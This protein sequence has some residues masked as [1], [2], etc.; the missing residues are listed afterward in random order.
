LSNHQGGILHQWRRRLEHK[1]RSNSKGS[2][3][4]TKLLYPFMI[5]LKD[6]QLCV[7]CGLWGKNL[8]FSTY[9]D[10]KKAWRIK[11]KRQ[12][13][14][15]KNFKTPKSKGKFVTKIP[16]ILHLLKKN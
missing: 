16:N 5:K 12:Q 6:K 11:G 15:M 4:R 13:W 9:G 2:E 10:G 8:V 7:A 3:K 1:R 14:C